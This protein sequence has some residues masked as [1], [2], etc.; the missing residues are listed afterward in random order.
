MTTS[1]RTLLEKADLALADL[2]TGGGMLLPD[3]AKRFMRMLT[4]QSK[5]LGM[6]TFV[7]MNSP[8]QQYPR[9]KLGGRILRPGREGTAVATV[10]RVKPDLSFIELDAKLFKGEVRLTDEVLEDN[11]ERGDLRQTVMELIADGVARDMEEIA[12][13]GNTTSPDPFLAVMDGLLVQV[14]SH[15]VDAAGGPVAKQLFT[16]MLKAMPAEHLRDKSVMRFLSSIDVDS[17][18]RNLLADRATAAGDKFLETDAPIVVS[19][20]PLAPIPLFPENL[21]PQNN[22]SAIILTNPKNVY[23]GMWRQIRIES[24][25]DISEGALKVVV[26]VRFDV[27]LSDEH[28]TTKSINVRL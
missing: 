17:N 3:Q 28:A 25:R 5:L 13:L 2:T 22:Q 6:V 21:G 10:D 24:A 9:I 18:Y 12:I 26:T 14:R 15:V 4:V 20:V 23:V 19:G 11:I 16:D 27:R 7:P 8:K 1:N